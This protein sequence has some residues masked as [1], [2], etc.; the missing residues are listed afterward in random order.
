MTSQL[1]V[2]RVHVYDTGMRVVEANLGG[3]ITE[4]ARQRGCLCS[5]APA[6]DADWILVEF[7]NTAHSSLF[8][9]TFPTQLSMR[10]PKNF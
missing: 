6:A 8:L 10:S 1:E 3:R 4:W 9:L 5:V 2:Q 7:E